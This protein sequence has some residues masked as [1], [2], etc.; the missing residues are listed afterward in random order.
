VLTSSRSVRV[1]QEHGLTRRVLRAWPEL[2]VLVSVVI[3]FLP[4]L[5]GSAHTPYDAEFFHYPLLRT[6]QGLL[7]SGTIPS[8]DGFSYGGVPLLANAQAAWLYPPHL[9]LDGAL[10][11]LGKPLTAQ[12]LD[13]LAVVHVAVAGLATAAVARGRRLGGAAAAF[14]GVFV[15][16]NGATLS[17]AQHVAMTETFAWIPLAVLMI[18]RLA[19]GL[20]ARRVVGLG[21][22]FALMITAG[23]VPLIPACMVLIVGVALARRSGQRIALLGALAGMAVGIGMAAAMLLPVVALVRVLPPLDAHGALPLSGLLTA[24]LPNAFGHWQGTPLAYMGP[25]GVTSSYYYIGGVALV[26]LPLAL[27]S[28]RTALREAIL[29][30][31]LL[32]ASFGPTG[33]AL[34]TA[35]QGLPTVG[36]LWRPEDLAY[37]ATVPLGLLLARGLARA[38]SAAQL[39]AAALALAVLVAVPFSARHHHG[40]HALVN[41]PWQM[42]LAVLLGGGLLVAASALRGRHPRAAALALALA[43]LTGCADLAAAVPGRYFVNSSGPATSAGPTLTGDGSP[44]LSALRK[45][46]APGER[47]AA[48]VANLPPTWPGFP[49]IWNLSDVNGFQ[50]Q[51]SKYQLERVQATGADFGGRNRI[52]PIVPALRAYFEEM[53]ARYVVLAAAHDPFARANGYRASYRDAIYHVYRLQGGLERAYAVDPACVRRFSAVPACRVGPRTQVALTGPSTRRIEIPAASGV[54]MLI[55]GEPWYPGWQATTPKGGL[56]VRRAGY[57]AAVA[58]PPGVTEVTLS[59]HPPGLIAGVIL[60]V[61]ALA[62]SVLLLWLRRPTRASESERQRPHR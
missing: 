16:L 61:L 21:V 56:A 36:H 20:T 29:V 60:S 52:F 48:D 55:T 27:S 42:V 41:A 2:A 38:S 6:V 13:V 35:I 14:A 43:A 62:G 8:W 19:T 22:V 33:G 58:V 11:L 57:L 46:L 53:D 40:L 37:A 3:A 15:V 25:G 4:T 17:Q 54:P 34:A 23:F 10:A 59:Y 50:P 45:L 7:S 24:V 26:M 18:D 44:V 47:V 12:T 32:L 28:G 49:P 39:S 51:F 1:Y 30:L 5:D 9:L 31:V